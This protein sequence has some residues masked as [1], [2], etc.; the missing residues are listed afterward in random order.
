M[1]YDK[2]KVTIDLEEYQDLLK[3]RDG[4]NSDEY[5]IAAKKVV[6]SMLNGRG[7]VNEIHF[8]LKKENILFS[9]N[10]DQRYGSA[11][12]FNDIVIELINPKTIKQ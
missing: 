3:I 7:N 2:P 12:N 9:V 4:F 11:I 8:V 6:A 1:G 5:V 10:A